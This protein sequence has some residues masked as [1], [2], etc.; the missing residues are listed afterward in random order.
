MEISEII[1]DAINYP[2]KHAKELLVYIIIDIFITVLG[3]ILG[4]GGLHLIC[5]T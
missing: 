5:Q 3:I 1:T 4:F 2:L